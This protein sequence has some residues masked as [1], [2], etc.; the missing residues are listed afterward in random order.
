M[1]D[2]TP[3]PAPSPEPQKSKRSRSPINKHFTTELDL[4]EGLVAVAQKTDY[5]TQLA[6]EEIDAAFLTALSGKITQADQLLGSATGDSADKEN[7][8]LDED[9]ARKAL[10]AQIEKVQKRAKR[11]YKAG[12]PARGKYFIGDRID[13][14]RSMLEASAKA[15]E[16]TLATDTLPGHKPADTQAL[17]DARTAYSASKP[18]QAGEQ[19]LASG[20]RIKLES[21]VKDIADGR[22]QIQYAADTVWPASNKANAAIRREFGLP[23]NRSLK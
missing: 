21:L 2:P 5:A 10:L 17:T 12:D 6:N 23:P 16:Q 19:S 4:T 3:N 15:L 8:T 22:R 14:S 20:D 13:A 1:S 11:K 18:A 9:T 7:S